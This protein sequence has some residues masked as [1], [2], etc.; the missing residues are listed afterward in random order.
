M[1]DFGK[2]A[3]SIEVLIELVGK[4]VD[5]SQKQYEAQEMFPL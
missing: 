5:I 1:L 4:Q 3:Y 2:A